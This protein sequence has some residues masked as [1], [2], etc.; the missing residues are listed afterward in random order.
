MSKWLRRVALGLLLSVLALAVVTLRAVIEGEAEMQ[1]SDR[2]F[3]EGDLRKATVHARRAAI[4]YAPG[5][6]HVG[7]AYERLIA[8]ASGAEAEGEVEVAQ[9]AWRAVRGAALETRHVS[10]PHRTELDQADRNL[11][12]LA[13]VSSSGTARALRA[14]YEQ[15][16][17]AL[18]KDSAPRA[19]WVL[20][21]VFGFVLSIAG[22]VWIAVRGI[23]PDGSVTFAGMRLGLALTLIGA[24]CW[25]IA[26]WKA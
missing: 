17:A 11:A 23:N 21:L 7:A 15:A 26:V 24:A 22:L 2:A 8:I 1:D 4:L 20:A 16:L 19:R 25:T 5:A 18:E 14:D 3:N 13:S 10:V 9:M 6:P 12:R